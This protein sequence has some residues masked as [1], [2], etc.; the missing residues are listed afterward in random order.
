MTPQDVIQFWL[1]DVGEKQWY[2]S[3]DA[4][5][6]RCRDQF[7]EAWSH[8]DTLAESWSG[9]R[10]GALATLI[11]TD[12]LPRN[13][14]RDEARSFA[15]DKLA[16]QT[17]DKAIAAGFDMQTEDAPRQFFY[18]PFMHS[19]EMGDQNRAVTLFEE[20][21]PGNNLRHARLHRDVI[22]SFGRFPWRNDALGRE[23]TPR[24]REFLEQ[25]GYAAMVK[26]TLSL[27]EA[28]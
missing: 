10:E 3:S 28:G 19:E 14:F 23:T 20:R 12:Q 5:D 17:A 1:E 27:D 2:E 8:A 18:M 11:L 15:T 13:M 6:Q 16:R 22:R 7:S 9:S 21:L 4:L 26:G 25:G 24:E